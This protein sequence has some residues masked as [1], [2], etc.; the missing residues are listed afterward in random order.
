MSAREAGHPGAPIQ[1]SLSVPF[2]MG[3]G[4]NNKNDRMGGS[5]WFG[6]SFGGQNYNGDVNL[7][8][9][10]VPLP[11]AVLLG[12][13]GLGGVGGLRRWLR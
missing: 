9:R 4:A 10:P 5:G 12:M 6:Y 1:P 2:Q 11:G 13:L 8:I 3:Y 7:N